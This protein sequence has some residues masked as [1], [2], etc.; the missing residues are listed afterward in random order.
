MP[1][2]VMFGGALTSIASSNQL[3]LNMILGQAGDVMYY[4]SLVTQ[5]ATGKW[6]CKTTQ[7]ALQCGANNVL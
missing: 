4:Q 5:K 2:A 7:P 3:C 6:T 1:A